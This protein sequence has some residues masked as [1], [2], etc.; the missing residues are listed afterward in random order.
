MSNLVPMVLSMASMV[1]IK[2]THDADG[3]ALA[4]PQNF[5]LDT[6]QNVSSDQKIDQKTAH[7]QN[8]MALV[9]AN[10]KKTVSLSFEVLESHAQA[11][12]AMFFG[13][14]TRSGSLVINH[15]E[16]GT[17]LPDFFTAPV[18]IQNIRTIHLGRWVA[19][20]SLTIK[21]GASHVA[22]TLET[23]P[24]AVLVSGKYRVTS[25]RYEF[26]AADAGKETKITW[27]CLDK[28]TAGGSIGT[29]VVSTLKIPARRTVN[30]TLFA[31]FTSISGAGL[32][33]QNGFLN[34][35][36]NANSYIWQDNGVLIL[37]SG[38]LATVLAARDITHR[39]DGIVMTSV[40]ATLPATGYNAILNPP[41]AALFTND[42]GVA[43]LSG[44]IG[45]LAIGDALTKTATPTTTGQYDQ[46]AGGVYTFV[47]A[48]AGASV[49]VKYLTDF[50]FTTVKPSL[51]TF[52]DDK[53]VTDADG[54]PLQRVA[55]VTP[56]ALGANQYAFGGDG[57]YYFANAKFG[58]T[59]F[60][61]YETETDTGVS[62]DFNNKKMGNGAVVAIDVSGEYEGQQFHF[63]Y[64][65]AKCKSMSMGTKN[66]DIS[67][68][69]FE[70]E[71]FSPRKVK[72]YGSL[73][74]TPLS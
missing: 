42:Q 47:A 16:A 68:V 50:L 70:F 31:G 26:A 1:H 30:M 46:D 10:G 17:V 37:H 23:N 6:I 24:D 20:T 71:V 49:T 55:L 11:L 38:V 63:K 32:T 66:E 25:G 35:T 22:A 9:A 54:M 67:M 3:K 5:G 51:G 8:E 19:N 53:G 34:T 43:L 2:Q 36:L 74:M 21:Q 33:R 52:V 7:G 4:V 15:D 62:V 27:I 72:S 44:T 73:S 58:E 48:D 39:T 69:K 65:K 64:A 45:A 13:G 56:L 18:K 12:N 41:G 40:V 59:L 29:T 61:D 14:E 57:T 28:T 60:I